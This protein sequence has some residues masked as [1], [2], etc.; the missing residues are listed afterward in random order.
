MRCEKCGKVICVN[1][2][3]FGRGLCFACV[4][5]YAKKKGGKK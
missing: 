5:K 4:Q 1:E 3:A 2:A